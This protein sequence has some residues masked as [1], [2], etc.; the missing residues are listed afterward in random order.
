MSELVEL[1]KTA[2][3]LRAAV[4]QVVVGQQRVVDEVLCA[5]MSGGHVLLE[6]VPGV[7]KTLLART[8]A[9]SLDLQFRRV[10]FTP[11]LM[12]ADVVGT[13]VFDLQKGVFH[14]EKGPVFTQVLL[15]DEINRTPPKSQAALLEA[16]Q[17][18]QVTIDGETH[19]LPSP[20][21]VLATQNPLDH[22][23]T[24]PL[25]EAQLDR[26][27]MK[28]LVD[29]P[30]EPEELEV[31]RRF[32]DGRLELDAVSTVQPVPG[33]S[34]DGMRAAL[35]QVHVEEAVIGWGR[36]LIALTRSSRRLA[37]GASPRA[38]MAL[39]AASRA[40]AALDGRAFVTPDDVKRMAR[41]VL[42][43][44]LLVTPDAELDGQDADRVL[45]GLLESLDVPR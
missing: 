26:F 22:E 18:R 34:L 25:P 19:P 45:T 40:H 29:Y 28:V 38:G 10:Q 20:F 23:G 15:A 39:L 13:K 31:Y 11:D 16:M 8:L 43:H 2:E 1:R 44:R 33:A 5:L 7:A 32:L 9:A 14:L 36:Q 30:A 17:E 24:Y 6:G 27:L 3:A 12:P 35:G 4:G 42:R 41:P 37:I 21:F